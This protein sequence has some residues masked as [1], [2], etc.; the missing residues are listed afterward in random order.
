MDVSNASMYD[1]ASALGEAV[2]LACNQTNKKE[3][4]YASTINPVITGVVKTY[5]EAPGIK[6]INVPTENG[7]TKFSEYEKLFS[8]TIGA[9]VISTPNYYGNIEDLEKLA[10]LAHSKN[11][12]FVVYTDPISLGL[13]KKPIRKKVFRKLLTSLELVLDDIQIIKLYE[14]S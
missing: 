11:A 14:I 10:E 7:V 5:T 13:L 6:L 9:I 4:L 12:L 1:G 2:L 3:V 8:D